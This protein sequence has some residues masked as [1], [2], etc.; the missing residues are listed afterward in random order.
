MSQSSTKSVKFD[1]NN[2]DLFKFKS[3]SDVSKLHVFGLTFFPPQELDFSLLGI[4]ASVEN[5]GKVFF[6]T[7]CKK[8]STVRPPENEQLK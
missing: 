8:G 7:D 6:F 1:V 2:L 5:F 3:K 4:V